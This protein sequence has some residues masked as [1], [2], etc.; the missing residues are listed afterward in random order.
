MGKQ[1]DRAPGRQGEALRR[2]GLSLPGVFEAH[3]WGELVLKAKGKVFVFLGKPGD[4]L[5]FSVK[6]PK[7]GERLLDQDWAEPTGYGLGKSGWITLT[8]DGG[9]PLSES[10]L[11]ALLE[12]SYRAVA[13]KT[14]VQELDE[15]ASPPVPEKTKTETKA[16]PA[17]KA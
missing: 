11:C 15:R 4:A 3:P 9:N 7:T 14:L 10:E 5:R 16:R 6:L 8:V 17:R 13:P 2:F 12:E 1:R